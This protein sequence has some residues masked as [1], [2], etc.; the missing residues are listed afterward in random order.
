PGPERDSSA[1]LLSPV[2]SL[3]PTTDGA[4]RW[5]QG[6]RCRSPRRS[7]NT[8]DQVAAAPGAA[9]TAEPGG[10]PGLNRDGQR[11]VPG[12]GRHRHLGPAVGL[13]N[14]IV[15][16]GPPVEHDGRRPC[17]AR[18]GMTDVDLISTHAPGSVDLSA[19][20][21]RGPGGQHVGGPAAEP[22]VLALH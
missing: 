8:P 12:G 10:G 7:G 19:V 15:V 11:V 5:P 18:E 3:L 16:H 14:L 6:P 17:A 9:L 22:D 13:E 2:K 4:Y 21:A 20:A 1:S